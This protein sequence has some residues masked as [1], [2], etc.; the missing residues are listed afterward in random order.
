MNASPQKS[1]L[2]TI[3]LAA[4]ATTLTASVIIGVSGTASAGEAASAD[5]A[6]RFV[7]EQSRKRVVNNGVIAYMKG[8]YS[9]AAAFNR[10]ALHQGLKTTHMAVVYSNQ[11]A[12]LGAQ[13]LY[14][15]ALD[16][17]DKALKLT[18]ANWQ[19]FSNRAA[20]NWLSGDKLQAKQDIIS[21]KALDSAAP[22]ITYNMNVFG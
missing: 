19:A 20:V 8:D 5:A 14:G 17:C 10:D 22:E 2:N 7:V 18:P 16:A 21:A 15:A 13:G 3:L 1:V 4:I 12:A 9:K 11:C 6:P